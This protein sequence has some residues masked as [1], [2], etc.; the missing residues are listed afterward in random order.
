MDFNIKIDCVR[1]SG[2]I[3]SVKRTGTFK[4]LSKQ[5][6]IEWTFDVSVRTESE[7]L[8]Y[9]AS[10]RREFVNQFI[11][12][13][14]VKKFNN[15]IFLDDFLCSTLYIYTFVNGYTKDY[16]HY[17]IIAYIKY[18]NKYFP[19][20]CLPDKMQSEKLLDVWVS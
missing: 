3:K 4:A 12:G 20:K 9:L 1:S 5:H 17:W 13:Y 7:S 16:L 8:V 11:C 18:Y 14:M 19:G 10:F 2:I 6:Y 15:N